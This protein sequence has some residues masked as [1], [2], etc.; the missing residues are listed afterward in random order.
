MFHPGGW[1]SCQ[2]VSIWLLMLKI[3]KE[4][5]RNCKNHK[6]KI[7]FKREKGELMVV[8]ELAGIITRR[9]T[10]S[11]SYHQ[12]NYSTAPPHWRCGHTL[13]RI[14]ILSF[15]DESLV[16]N[17][18]CG[19]HCSIRTVISHPHHNVADWEGWRAATHLFSQ[20][21]CGTVIELLLCHGIDLTWLGNKSRGEIKGGTQGVRTHLSSSPGKQS[22]FRLYS[23]IHRGPFCAGRGN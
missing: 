13:L 23:S 11:I 6:I 2:K 3:Y 8:S 22:S 17:S 7:V 5:H 12:S 9:L 14:W 18:L 10:P 21:L 19:N 15:P 20:N 4:N 1:P 16:T